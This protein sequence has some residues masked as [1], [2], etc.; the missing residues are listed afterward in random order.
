MLVVCPAVRVEQRL[1]LRKDLLHELEVRGVVGAKV[2]DEGSVLDRVVA[3][4]KG[5]V[6]LRVKTGM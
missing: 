2:H 5:G 6:A 1:Q 4:R 3:I